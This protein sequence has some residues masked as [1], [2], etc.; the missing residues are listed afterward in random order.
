MFEE[1]S[2]IYT[3]VAE[4]TIAELPENWKAFWIREECREGSWATRCYYELRD[5]E[6]ITHFQV[7][8]EA[9][10][11]LHDAWEISRARNDRWSIVFF[12]VVAPGD[13]HITFGHQDLDDE[14]V[15]QNDRMNEFEEKT[16]AGRN[17]VS[18]VDMSGAFSLTPEM[19]KSGT[20]QP[21]A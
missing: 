16:F 13:L 5:V 2:K 12:F 11:L 19:L 17:V 6:E 4:R 15:T 8:D 1:L 18:I 3:E 21:N 14:S 7:S 10:E 20:F 9:T